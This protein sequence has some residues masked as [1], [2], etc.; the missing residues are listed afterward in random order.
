MP[1]LLCAIV[2]AVLCGGCGG[3]Y[4]LT[5]PDQV[6]PAGGDAAA[7]VR[8]Q[9]AEVYRVALPVEG[10]A[11]RF[12]VAGGPE[13]GAYTDEN[14]YAGTTVP[15]PDKPGCYKMT[16]DHMDKEGDEIGAEVS[17]YA[18]D[19]N[20]PVVVVDLES[21]PPLGTPAAATARD[22]L[23]RVAA[24]AAI[25]Y[26]TQKPVKEHIH[27]HQGLRQENFPD[28]PVLTWQ[29][30]SYHIVRTGSGAIKMSRIVFENRM[31]SQLPTL[32]KLFGRLKAGVTNSSATAKLYADAGI[33][34]IAL[35]PM[36]DVKVI[37]HVSWDTLDASAVK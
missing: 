9:R 13:R 10:A 32:K 18:I 21:L 19:A 37:K 29:R 20:R 15:V 22:A 26:V 28:G 1:R 24:E 25:I 35:A 3:N 8:L 30:E 12:R 17:C 5:V 27:A 7:V 14:G 11:L 36:D 31:V 16:V 2:V 23:Q 33:D 6:A 4:I 34:V